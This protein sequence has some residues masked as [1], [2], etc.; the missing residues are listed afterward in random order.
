M[1][2]LFDENVPAPLRKHPEPHQVTTVQEQGWAGISNGDLVL[3]TNG[4]FDVLLLAD[5]NLRYQQNLA[6][7]Q[8]ALFELPTNRW[9]ALQMMLPRIRQAVNAATPG[10][11]TSIELPA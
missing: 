2:I 6:N 5:K 4:V 8:V 7:R 9:P 11:Y 3:R 1:T 10:S